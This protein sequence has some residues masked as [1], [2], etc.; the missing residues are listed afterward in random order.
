MKTTT[1]RQRLTDALTAAL[2]RL[3]SDGFLEGDAPAIQLT[4]PKQESHG[5][6]ACNVALALAKPAKRN[7][8]EIATQLVEQLGDA[9]G[10][11]ERVE[12]AG[13]GF[14]NLFVA[15]AAWHKTLSNI[16]AAGADHIRSEHGE[17]RRILL[18]YVSAN[19]TGPLH[20]A[21]GRGAVTGDVLAN[22]LDAAGFAVEREFYVNDLGHQ[23][24]VLARSIH[25]RY[26]EL[27][28]QHPKH[29]E[30]F[31]P[32]EYVKE[33]AEVLRQELGDAHLE[34]DEDQWLATF[35]QRG[36]D[37]ML[38]R[39]RADLEAFGVRFDRF[40]SERALVESTDLVGM[41]DELEAKGMVYEQEGKKWFR[42]TDFG[43]DKDRVVV[44]EDGRTTYFCSDLAYH[45][46]KMSRG[47]E[48]LINVWGADHGGYIARV[49]AG[50]SAFGYDP[51]ALEIVLIQMVSLTRGG[52]AVRMGKR[53]GTA[54]WL[55]D[56]VNEAGKDATRYFF[57]L[58]RSDSQ[59]DFDLD[60]ATQ[61]SLDNPVYYAQ[62]GHAR[63]CSMIAKA[64]EQGVPQALDGEGAL[65]ALT[66]PEELT[67]IKM[68][69]RAPEVVVAAAESRE[70]HQVVFYVQELIA[71]FHSYYTRYSATERVISD[72]AAKTRARL[73]LCGALRT[74]LAA[75]LA[76][77]GVD[78]PE[79]MSL[80]AADEE[81]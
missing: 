50:L 78:A 71:L 66:L 3:Y 62:M 26:R 31:Y 70:P 14:I 76:V 77:L 22:L 1:L 75:L 33:I 7:P 23:V 55:R 67:L 73:L 39:V 54:V 59:F 32:G 15:P 38:D 60:L 40:V 37:R 58:R 63:L 53:L 45:R 49:K 6:F 2:G 29:P 46:D 30:D 25:V 41:A 16:L 80:E 56:V 19:P 51:D 36:V 44:R 61:K 4:P 48:R 13:P 5:D 9:D 35:R 81:R 12:I 52:E 18:E 72:D 79:R 69:S 21:H 24:D 8:R 27:F 43:D 64:A 42:S 74:T 65:D 17:G 57:L 11:L 20:V 68:M 47:F 28:G 10:L 34:S